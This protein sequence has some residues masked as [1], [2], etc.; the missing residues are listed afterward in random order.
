MSTPTSTN[1]PSPTSTGGSGGGGGGGGGSSSPLL[2][3]VALGFGV[4]FT[5][6][7]IIVGVKYCFRYNQRNRQARADEFADP[8]DMGPVPRPH[9]RRREKKLMTM[10]EVNER[11]PLSKYKTWRSSRESAGLPSTG[12]IDAPPSRAGSIRKEVG[13]VGEVHED[14]SP[15]QEHA[16]QPAAPPSISEN[17][18][19]RGVPEPSS[20]TIPVADGPSKTADAHSTEVALGEKT[21]ALERQE[22]VDSTGGDLPRA[23]TTQG[24]IEEDDDDDEDEHIHTALPPDLV[25]TPGDTCAICLDTL[26]DDDEIRGLTCGHAFHASCIDPW[27]TSRRACCPLCK[28]DYYTPK[29]RPEGEAADSDRSGRRHQGTSGSRMNMPL[30]PQS[31]WIGA[32]GAFF[33]PTSMPARYPG[34]QQQQRRGRTGFFTPEGGPRRAQRVPGTEAPTNTS[35]NNVG[36]GWMPRVSNPFRNMSRPTMPQLRLPGRSNQHQNNAGGESSVTP[37]QLEAGSR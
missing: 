18:T 33:R 36:R 15:A 20:S 14:N 17:Q 12:G 4:V 5:N 11:F 21:N 9:R 6:L 29:P 27:L 1:T 32:R 2:F 37:G 35:P 10:D 16:A 3:F 8:I 7:W 22:T 31:A 13:T 24:T 30:P 23:I 26:N 34:Q 19:A 25:N 28:A